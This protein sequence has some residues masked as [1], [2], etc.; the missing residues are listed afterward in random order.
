MSVWHP[1]LRAYARRTMQIVAVLRGTDGVRH[2]AA[3]VDVSAGGAFFRTHE[4]PPVGQ[5]VV[6]EV[7][8]LVGEE[9]EV[10]VS[11]EV[12]WV[13]ADAPGVLPGFGARW[14]LAESENPDALNL[15]VRDVLRSRSGAVDSADG[16]HRYRFVPP[17]VQC[18]GFEPSRIV[19]PPAA[20]QKVRGASPVLLAASAELPSRMESGAVIALGRQALRMVVKRT[21]PTIGTKVWVHLLVDD[22]A[23]LAP[24]V[25][26]GRVTDSVLDPVSGERWFDLQLQ[27][28]HDQA[29]TGG[30]EAW[31]ARLPMAA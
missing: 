22:D 5:T 10:R 23:S 24:L 9:S 16:M 31:V 20:L 17:P 25:C 7:A 15:L 4:P 13:L 3:T 14:V 28:I 2:E 29:L 8:P 1:D 21:P 18:R 30:F 19:L 12:R 26:A 6:A 27:E 11:A